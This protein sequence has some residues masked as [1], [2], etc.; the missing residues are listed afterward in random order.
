MTPPA[1]ARSRPFRF[2]LSGWADS[3]DGWRSLALRAEEAGI[4]VLV[5]PDHLAAGLPSP[6]LPLVL[7]AEATSTLRV[8]TLVLNND[9]WHPAFLA[10]DAAT[11]DALTEGRFELGVGAG[12]AYGEYAE[13]GVAFERPPVRVDRLIESVDAMRRLLAGEEVTVDGHHVHLGA[14]RCWRVPDPAIRLLVGGG[15]R[16]LLQFAATTADTVALSGLGPTIDGRRHEPTDWPP[17]RLDAKV[18]LV[19]EAATQAGRAD[20]VELNAL[21]QVLKVTEDPDGEMAQFAQLA[22]VPVEVVQA[23]PFAHFGSA[24]AIAEDL[25]AA[26]DRWGISYVSVFGPFLEDARQVIGAL[27]RAGAR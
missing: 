24:A 20:T 26:R 10:R 22:G 13:V 11:L 12:H 3:R 21:V 1:A 4:D 27:E 23:T 9:F 2:S 15:N 5:M 8:G 7:A 17:D 25:L 18:D 19:W 14:H 16:R 6:L